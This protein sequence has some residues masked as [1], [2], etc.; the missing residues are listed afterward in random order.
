VSRP[1]PDLSQ[2]SLAA[3]CEAALTETLLSGQ[4][5]PGDYLPPEQELCA[6]LGVGRSTL[7]E[8]VGTMVAKGLLEKRHGVGIRVVE[9]SSQ[10][11]GSMLALLLQRGQVTAAE[12]LE[13]RRLYEVQAARWAAERAD[14]PGRH[15]ISDALA[16]MAAAGH[17]HEAFAEADLAFHFA[18]AKASGNRVLALMVEAIRAPLREAILASLQD[19]FQ[20]QTTMAYHAGILDAIVA[21]D[22]RAAGEAMA[23]HLDDT[24]RKLQAWT[25][26]GE[27]A[28]ES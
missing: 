23:R 10:A 1:R 17:D 28:H 6:Q 3:R 25:G 9:R 19:A 5:A 12:L 13:A 27:T 18:V 14:D 22:R 15:A 24:A 4:V 11:A 26:T 7:R 21:G 16:R 8:A 20:P 2:E